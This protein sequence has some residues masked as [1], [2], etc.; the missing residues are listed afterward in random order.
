MHH[1]KKWQWVFILLCIVDGWIEQVHWALIDVCQLQ[2]LQQTPSLMP[3]WINLLNNCIKVWKIRGREHVKMKGEKN[4]ICMNGHI[5][6]FVFFLIKP[7]LLGLHSLFVESKP[8]EKH[9]P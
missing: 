7:S 6:M 5:W 1:L 4:Y 8:W 3:Y 9:K 2:Q